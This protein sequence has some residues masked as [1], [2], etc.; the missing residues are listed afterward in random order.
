MKAVRGVDRTD[1]RKEEKRFR[2]ALLHGSTWSTERK[3]MKR[4]KGTFDGFF[5]IEHR[6]RKQEMEEQFNKQ[7]KEG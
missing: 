3:Y 4:Y 1:L 5:G 7:A 6:V 2:C